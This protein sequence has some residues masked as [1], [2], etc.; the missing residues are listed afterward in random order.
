[1]KSGGIELSSRWGRL[2]ELHVDPEI[3]PPILPSR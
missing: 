3:T 1:M 2:M